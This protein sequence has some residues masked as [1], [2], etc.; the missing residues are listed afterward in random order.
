M[1]Q[2]NAGV[3]QIDINDCVAKDDADEEVVDSQAR[4]RKSEWVDGN[5][6]KLSEA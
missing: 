5:N 2:A 1:V 4:S 3:V 6:A